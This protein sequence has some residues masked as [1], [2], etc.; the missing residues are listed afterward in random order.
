MRGDAY[1]GAEVRDLTPLN[2]RGRGFQRLDL[3]L[4]K[5]FGELT[6]GRMWFENVV[7]GRLAVRHGY[8]ELDGFGSY[9]V[10]L[11][12]V[13]QIERAY[14]REPW[15][16]AGRYDR[17]TW[18]ETAEAARALGVTAAAARIAL[19][20]A[21]VRCVPVIGRQ[22]AKVWDRKGVER[23]LERRGRMTGDVPAGYLPLEA[24]MECGFSRSTLH[25]HM[26]QNDFKVVVLK[27]GAQRRA[28]FEPETLAKLFLRRVEVALA[29]VR[30]IQERLEVAA[31]KVLSTDNN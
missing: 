16:V 6:P 25:R 15:F 24:V 4:R 7:L 5:K 3:W 18:M 10:L 2:Y 23:V 11:V 22:G 27:Q 8:A 21:R 13:K 9:R 19:H 14:D 28:F 12:D 26:R 17:E 1:S 30:D 29:D 31:G 20:T